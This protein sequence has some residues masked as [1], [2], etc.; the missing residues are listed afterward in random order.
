[1]SSPSE[2]EPVKLIASLFSPEKELVELVVDELSGLFGPV[3]WV[4]R[5]C[6]FDR[7]RYYEREMGW[8]L[9][10][11]FVSF[12]RLVRPEDI[13]DI[14]HRTNEFEKKY[15]KGETRRINIDP[16]YISAERLVLATGKNY[17]HRIYLSRGIYADL[18]LVFHKGYF[19]PL[20][21]TYRDYR[22][23]WIREAFRKV[24]GTYMLERKE[25]NRL[26]QQHDSLRQG[27]P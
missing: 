13:V 5:E 1:M 22:E 4:S 7:T 3:D 25:R 19:E 18:T 16:G 24:R 20:P 2:S 14:K 21:W 26:D 23:P 17:V 10:R 27:R 11:R 9:H 6:F 12:E 15:L 8:P